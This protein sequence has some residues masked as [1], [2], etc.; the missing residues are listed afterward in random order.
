V[1]GA[2]PRAQ[3]RI[4][5]VGWL[6]I[7]ARLLAMVLLLIACVPLFYLWRLGRGRNPWPR[8]FLGSIASIAGVRITITGER[9]D[10]GTFLL[11]NHVSWIDIPALA[12]ATGTA[13]VAHDGL[14]DVPLLRWL[15][16]MNETIFIA[17]HDRSS[18]AR[19]VAQVREAVRNTRPLTIFPE[20]TTS[21]GTALLPFK[22]SLLSA[23]DPLPNGIAVR[24]VLLDYGD[25]AA[26]IAWVG[27]EPGLDNFIRILARARSVKLTVHLL[28]PLSGDALANR[29]TMTAAAHEALSA[30]LAGRVSG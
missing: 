9:V 26:D 18:I 12:G 14:A 16:E 10:Q 2:A 25:E 20:G 21:D 23:L 7:A 5:A 15:C 27:E 1:T 3:P 28:P 17:R 19:Q 22:S 29:K 30:R 4:S 8:A 24:P 11:I 6:R 13:F